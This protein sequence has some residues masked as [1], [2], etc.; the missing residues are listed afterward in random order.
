MGMGG[1]GNIDDWKNGNVNEVLDWEWN[2]NDS[3]GMGGNGNSNS[4]SHTPLLRIL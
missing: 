1:I 2:G 3:T 4:H